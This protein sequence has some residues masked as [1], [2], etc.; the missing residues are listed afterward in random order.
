MNHNIENNIS[1]ELL[2]Q[3]RNFSDN[4]ILNTIKQAHNYS[5]ETIQAAKHIAL[6][7]NLLFDKDLVNLNTEA[8]LT[9]EAKALLEEEV[10]V[11]EIMKRF[12]ARGIDIEAASK[13]VHS[14]SLKA[15]V[16]TKTQK[17]EEEE[18]VFKWWYLFIVFII[19]R[20]FLRAIRNH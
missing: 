5:K 1:K 19:I 6:E 13:A 17:V 12:T 15:E 10:S 14:A 9:S 2:E 4:R 18:G 7:R 8:Q 16:N 11:D 3:T 20:A